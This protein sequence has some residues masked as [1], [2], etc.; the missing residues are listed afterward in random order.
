[1][2]VRLRHAL[3]L[4]RHGNDRRATAG[5][6]RGHLVRFVTSTRLAADEFAE[7]GAL[8]DQPALGGSPPPAPTSTQEGSPSRERFGRLAA[9]LAKA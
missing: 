2:R 4:L 6:V 1:M 7:L 5:R 3:S 8:G 9:H